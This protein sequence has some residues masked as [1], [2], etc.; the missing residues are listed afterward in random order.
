MA[1][2][3]RSTSRSATGTVRSFRAGTRSYVA[4]EHGAERRKRWSAWATRSRAKNTHRPPWWTTRSWLNVRVLVRIDL[5]H[6]HPWIDRQGQSP[7]VWSVL[8][9]IAQ[10]TERLQVGT[11]VTCPLIRTH[12]AIIAQAAATMSLL[13]PG[14]FFLGVGSGE[15]LNEHILGDQW[16]P[17]PMRQE[18]LTEAVDLMR[19][20]WQGK[21]TT[22]Y[23]LHYKVEQARLYGLPPVPPPVFIAAGGEGGAEMAGAQGDGL[24]STSPDSELLQAFDRGGGTGKPRIAML[25]VCWAETETEALHTAREIWPNSALPGNLA[26]ELR[27]PADFEA[28]SELV[29]PEDISR[30]IPCGPDPERHVVL[31]QKFI[32]AGYDHIYIHQIG[33]DQ[34]GFID[35]CRREVFPRFDMAPAQLVASAS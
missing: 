10:A 28:A 23:G 21:L 11:G 29:R 26:R 12:P 8:G 7:F 25:H 32:D 13:M 18:M 4:S 16:P 34:P 17:A 15:N 27:L 1:A 9:A 22:R 2:S 20:L 3:N 33:P 6:F 35:F 5:G 14:R 30:G 31:V 24:I 19:E